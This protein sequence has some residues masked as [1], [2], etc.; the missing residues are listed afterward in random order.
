MP[1]IPDVDK[2]LIEALTALMDEEK[3]GTAFEEKKV[4]DERPEAS[5][6][7]DDSDGEEPVSLEEKLDL[8]RAD[9]NEFEKRLLDAVVKPGTL[10]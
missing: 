3:F 8:I 10:T 2:N 1:G 7:D 9:C 5:D 6:S 4:E